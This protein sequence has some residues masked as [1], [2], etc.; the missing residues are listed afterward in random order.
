MDPIPSMPQLIITVVLIIIIVL[1]CVVICVMYNHRREDAIMKVATP[2]PIHVTH[3]C[4]VIS[5]QRVL[6]YDGSVLAPELH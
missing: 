2:L 4:D 1:L 5:Y 6:L 3:N